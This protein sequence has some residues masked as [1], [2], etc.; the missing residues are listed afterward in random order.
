MNV[1]ALALAS[2]FAFRQV[3]PYFHEPFL[4]DT[5]VEN[6]SAVL[7]IDSEVGEIESASFLVRPSSDLEAQ[8]VKPSDLSGPKGA[9]I[10]ASAIDVKTVKVWWAGVSNWDSDRHG[11]EGKFRHGEL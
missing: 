3:D 4:P 5:P 9:A 7:E 11:R 1:A 6:T 10:P 2:L 8:D